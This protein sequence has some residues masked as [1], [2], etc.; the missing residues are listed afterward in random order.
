[1]R[2][3]N[4]R[5]SC[6][7]CLM[8]PRFKFQFISLKAYTLIIGLYW[9]W[10]CVKAEASTG[11]ATHPKSCGQWWVH[12][13]L[14]G[15]RYSDSNLLSSRPFIV[16]PPECLFYLVFNEILLF[17]HSTYKVYR[18]GKTLN[19]RSTLLTCLKDFFKKKKQGKDCTWNIKRGA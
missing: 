13:G 10:L 2:A 15:L 14:W 3:S 18:P 6:K 9:V 12:L 11:E 4:K 19:M 1:M 17:S 5:R 16:V 7:I 8:M